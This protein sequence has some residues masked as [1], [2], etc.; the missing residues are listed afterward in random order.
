MVAWDIG[1]WLPGL[2]EQ[3]EA[4]RGRTPRARQIPLDATDLLEQGG[5]SRLGR[6]ELSFFSRDATYL[7]E[8]G[9]L[10]SARPSTGDFGRRRPS[11]ARQRLLDVAEL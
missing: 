7:Y 1:A 6:A 4:L 5:D 9:E 8:Q 3:V 2:L 11:L 10:L